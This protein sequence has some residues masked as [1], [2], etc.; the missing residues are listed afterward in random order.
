MT[1]SLS[2]SPKR[3]KCT[4]A[5][6]ISSEQGCGQSNIGL[7][8]DLISGGEREESEEVVEIIENVQGVVDQKSIEE[9]EALVPIIEGKILVALKKWWAT[10]DLEGEP[11]RQNASTVVKDGRLIASAQCLVCHSFKNLSIVKN[12]RVSLHNYIRHCSMHAVNPANTSKKIAKKDANSY[13]K[14]DTRNKPQP[15]LTSFFKRVGTSSQALPEVIAPKVIEIAGRQDVE[16]DSA[17]VDSLVDENDN[18]FWEDGEHIGDFSG[19][20]KE[21]ISFDANDDSS[22]LSIKK[23]KN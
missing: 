18:D 14:E 15:L 5:G 7:V 1:E 3:F 11:T 12:S 21:N 9:L 17:L 10:T 20:V 8:I 23:Q 19:S 2:P 6:E 4:K 13:T 22:A 16:F